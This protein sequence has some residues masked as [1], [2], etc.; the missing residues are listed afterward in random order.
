MRT[1][2]ETNAYSTYNVFKGQVLIQIFNSFLC[3]IEAEI[4][5]LQKM[6]NCSQL[7]FHFCIQLYTQEKTIS[8]FILKKNFSKK[9]VKLIKFCFI[10]IMRYI[11]IDFNGV[12]VYWNSIVVVF[13]VFSSPFIAIYSICL[14][15]F[16][17][18][19]R[20]ICFIL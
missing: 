3:L 12:T 20:S 11:S 2:N 9:A 17:S 14:N 1:I 16:L 15:T 4:L 10:A 18:I 19:T 8:C 13:C 5:W 6:H 7:E